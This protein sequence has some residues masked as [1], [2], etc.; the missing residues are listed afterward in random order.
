MNDDDNFSEEGMFF[1][2]LVLDLKLTQEAMTMVFAA[3]CEAILESIR[4]TPLTHSGGDKTQEALREFVD[5]RMSE[6]LNG[7]LAALADKNHALASAIHSAVSVF[8]PKT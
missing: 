7:K 3:R 5:T 4:D 6:I 1:S 8:L 2:Q